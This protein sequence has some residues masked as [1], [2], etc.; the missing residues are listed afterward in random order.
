MMVTSKCAK[1]EQ[2]CFKEG[3]YATLTAVPVEVELPLGY[4]AVY[5]EHENFQGNSVVLS[6]HDGEKNFRIAD[7]NLKSVKSLRV[8]ANVPNITAKERDDAAFEDAISGSGWLQDAFATSSKRM[9]WYNDSKFGCFVHWG[10]YSVAGGEWGG[11]RSGYAEH[12]QR[13]AQVNQ[14]DYKKH[15]IEQFNPTEF[16]ADE[17]I[18]TIKDAGMKFFVLTAK[19]HDGFAVYHSDA[20]PY[21][22]RMTP[23]KD[24][25]VL[26]LRKACDKYG[27]KFGLYYSHAFDWGDPDGP[28]NDWEF[29]NGGGDK[30]LFEG[31]LGLWF[32]QHP[33]LVPRTAK[34]YVDKKSIPQIVELIQK[35]RLDLIW[36]DTS[37][38]LPASENLRIL[39]AIRDTCP[40]VVV[41]GRLARNQRF[42][43][44]GDYNNTG[45]RAAETFPTPGRWETI[46][47]TNESYG[48]S[49]FDKSHKP[50]EHFIKLLIKSAARG[51]N[52]LMNLGPDG[53][54]AIDPV[55]LDIVAAIGK[56]M[57]ANGESIYGTIRSPLTVQSFGEVT[58]KGNKLYLHIFNPSD[59]I[60][61]GGVVNYLD[62]VY[63]LTDESKTPLATKRISNLDTEIT[64]PKN[65]EPYSV[66]V[67]EFSD[68]LMHGG[69]RLISTTMP[70]R[71]H[72]Y[73]ATYISP[74]LGHGDGKT[75]NDHVNNFNSTGQSIIWKVRTRQKTAYKLTVKYSTINPDVK[76]EYSI[77]VNGVT[78]V[79]AITASPK[80]KE[81]V[82]DT[83]DVEIAGEK[84][85][86]FRPHK[87][88]GQFLHLYQVDLTPVDKSFTEAVHVEEDTTDL[89]GN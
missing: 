39:K 78:H 66:V 12:M 52:V 87:L 23:Y 26:A 38:K 65:V 27:I 51:G 15:F 54:G 69:G 60:T 72:T 41:N 11:R 58:L 42:A 44:C 13:V 10:V 85:I 28:G 18:R 9:Q 61:L 80:F 34:Y 32:D 50:P 43:Q 88:D 30:K 89:G 22:M 46:P 73:D 1:S 71:L 82:Y 55:D 40:N 36:F 77:Y 19:H 63:M 25:P 14:E 47:T 57:K 70:E 81:Y 74:E 76:G 68:D 75:G 37:H 79:K 17:W 4:Q 83:F 62:K 3:E 20:F 56:W 59:V 45:D 6:A 29:T 49:A 7:T 33:E 8:L 53:Q 64:L 5:Y 2:Q 48:Y 84:D 24:D 16:D 31:E 67:A 86:V 35:Y 21:D